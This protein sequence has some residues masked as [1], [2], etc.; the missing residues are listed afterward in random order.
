MH[1]FMFLTLF[2]GVLC[3]YLLWYAFLC[4]FS[5]FA[6]I[7]TRERERERESWLVCLNCMS[8]VTVIWLFFTVPW[9][10]LQCVTVVVPDHT[11]LLFGVQCLV[12]V[13]LCT[14]LCPI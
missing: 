13:L 9:D 2:V 3:W 11:H 1:C 8:D 7:L 6:V 4:V 12:L 14:T 10:A 5:S